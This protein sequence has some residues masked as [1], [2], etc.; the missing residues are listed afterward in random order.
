[1][2]VGADGRDSQASLSSRPEDGADAC[3]G[4]PAA[5]S[6]DGIL[7]RP[8]PDGRTPVPARA[9]VAAGVAVPAVVSATGRTPRWLTR[10]GDGTDSAADG[11]SAAVLVASGL[12][13]R[14]TPARPSAA[15]AVC[16]EAVRLARARSAGPADVARARGAGSGAGRTPA[17][18]AAGY[19]VAGGAETA[20]V[21]TGSGA[22]GEPV[23]AGGASGAAAV[24]AGGGAGATATAGGAGSAG[25]AGG[26]GAGGRGGRKASGSR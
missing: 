16:D 4:S 11:R 15:P 12:C 1:V 10:A 13:L 7:A 2:A 26:S 25:D 17:A 21:G 8:T 14:S 24:T 23:T 18:A 6:T 19:V 5:S 22:T 3:E 20:G 9:A